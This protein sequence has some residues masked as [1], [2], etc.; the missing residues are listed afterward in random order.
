MPAEAVDWLLLEMRADSVVA[1]RIAR[2]AVILLSD[3]SVVNTSG[4]DMPVF[5][6]ISNDSVYVVIWARNHLPVMTPDNVEIVADVAAHD[7][8][9]S[10]AAAY[11]RDELPLVELADGAFGLL[12]GD[13]NSNGSVEAGDLI[14]YIAQTDVGAAGYQAA[15]F[16]LDGSVDA[17]DFNLYLASTLAG[18]TSQVP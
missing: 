9:T 7:F 3:W 14:L 17:L 4:T 5:Q 1:S 13:A 10:I 12:A 18:A 6:G 15:D 16:N 11:G 2:Q 8:T